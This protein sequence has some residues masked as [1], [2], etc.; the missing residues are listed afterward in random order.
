MPCFQDRSANVYFQKL[1]KKF[2]WTKEKF[3][4]SQ[5]LVWPLFYLLDQWFSAVAQ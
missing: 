2:E 3:K 1:K 5:Y 4:S